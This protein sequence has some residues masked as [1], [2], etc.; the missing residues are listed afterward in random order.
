MP[1]ELVDLRS[2][3]LITP[4]GYTVSNEGFFSSI[5]DAIVKFFTKLIGL[6]ESSS[7]STNTGSLVIKKISSST[8][9]LI[10][11]FFKLKREATDITGKSKIR[12]EDGKEVDA[13]EVGLSSFWDNQVVH[14]DDKG[15]I[16]KR[17]IKKTRTDNPDILRCF[18]LRGNGGRERQIYSHTHARQYLE[19]EILEIIRSCK[20][21]KVFELD[22]C[23]LVKYVDKTYTEIIEKM[24]EDINVDGTVSTERRR[25]Y[26]SM[27]ISNLFPNNNGK[28]LTGY[29]HDSAVKDSDNVDEG[30]PSAV[31]FEFIMFSDAL[32]IMTACKAIN[33]KGISLIKD[34]IT[35]ANIEKAFDKFAGQVAS[36]VTDVI[37]TSKFKEIDENLRNTLPDRICKE[38]SLV[39]TD[40]YRLLVKYVISA[41]KVTN[42][43]AKS[44][45]ACCPATEISEES[46]INIR[47][48]MKY[49]DP[50][51]T[52]YKEPVS[53]LPDYR[54]FTT[55]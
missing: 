44:V 55:N 43:F 50:Y 12:H 37:S 10:D 7:G 19:N 42:Y 51:N 11:R 26:A 4:K 29:I 21:A 1:H 6:G 14:A 3:M 17:T 31:Y 34:T 53:L 2:S 5:K 28:D 13:W 22:I 18:Y 20:N 36:D 47:K 41:H 25:K 27:I 15:E 39:F 48:P 46:Y 23:H 30:I 16:R 35:D 8:D 32:E 45:M 49:F 9:E 54:I 38:L 33:K 40:V 24:V 52:V